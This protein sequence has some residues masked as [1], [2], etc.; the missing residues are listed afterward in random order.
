MRY[1]ST[2]KI[3]RELRTETSS[4]VSPFL[5]TSLVSARMNS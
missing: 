4:M 3:G 2:L 1:W 5:S